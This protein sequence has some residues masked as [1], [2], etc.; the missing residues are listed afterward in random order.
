MKQYL[1]IVLLML[2]SCHAFAQDHTFLSDQGHERLLQ[3]Y[4]SPEADFIELITGNSKATAEEEYLRL[5]NLFIA[6]QVNERTLYANSFHKGLSHFETSFETN[7]HVGLMHT[8]L[9]IQQS[10]L[11]WNQ[12]K[13][14]EGARSLYKAHRLFRKLNK[15]D[16]PYDYL[17][18][19]SVFNIFLSQI[20]AQFQFLASLFGL[21]GDMEEGFDQLNT[22]VINTS[23]QS[24]INYEAMVLHAYCLL[25]FG[26]P[27]IKRVQLLM[28]QSLNSQSPLLNFIVAS[29]SVKNRM[30]DEGIN[31]ISEIDKKTITSFPLLYYMKGRLLL[32]QLKP[33]SITMLQQFDSIYQG[34]SFRTDALMRQAWYYHLEEEVE[35]RDSLMIR[36]NKQYKLP[37]S[38]DKQAK[39]EIASLPNTPACLL[40]VRLLFDGGNF[41]KAYQVLRSAPPESMASYNV[42]EYYY[43]LGRINTELGRYNEATACFD[44]TIELSHDNTRYFGPYAAI[45][46]AKIMLM[47]KDTIAARTYLEKA[48]HLNNGEYQQDISRSISSLLNE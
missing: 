35:M 9:L 8:T 27:D 24:A 34:H 40:K 33:G 15:D 19:Q 44:K 6:F 16:Y 29:L 42:A 45:E 11:F 43:R 20:P 22:Y 14:S 3:I 1:T 48:R 47:L 7:A 41:D 12:D 31:Y 26:R 13:T 18:L 38:N 2:A 17:K 25:K 46:A 5:Y 10:L 36:V 32:N 28:E 23:Q 37:T 39:K 4:Q 21:E 30:S